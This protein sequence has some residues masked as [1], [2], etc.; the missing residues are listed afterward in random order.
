VVRIQQKRRP[1]VP[2]L[3]RVDDGHR[4]VLMVAVI[5]E[6]RVGHHDD[7][8]LRLAEDLDEILDEVIP[9]RRS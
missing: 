7:I 9:G 6:E 2:F 1:L 3:E 4:G 5:V 8:R